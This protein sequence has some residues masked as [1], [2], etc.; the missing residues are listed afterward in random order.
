MRLSASRRKHV[1]RGCLV[2]LMFLAMPC[3]WAAT[4]GSLLV[5]ASELPAQKTASVFGQRIAYYDLGEGPTIVLVHGYAS[6]ARFDWGNV[7]LPL[8]KHYR[9][10]AL[11]QIGWGQSDKPAIDYSMQTFVDFLGEFLRTLKVDH[12]SLAGESMGGWVVADYAIQALAPTNTGIYALPRPEKLILSDAAGL[13]SMHTDG[14][15]QVQGTLAD[16]AG[17]QI[18]FHDKSRVTPEFVRDAWAMKM[19]ANDGATQRLLRSNPKLDN[20][21]VG[22]KLTAITIP[23]LVIWGADDE[24]VPLADGQEYA[25]KIP[26]ARLVVVPASG[27]CP[28]AEQPDAFIAAVNEFLH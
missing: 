11:D 9:V 18:V 10:L 25:K 22:D 12:F 27:H 26:Q 13:R 5:P 24:L 16:A 1:M 2:L 6:Q 15:V 7:L 28:A 20:E 17:I 23:A 19:K 3:L 21:T 4:S 14:P 8:S